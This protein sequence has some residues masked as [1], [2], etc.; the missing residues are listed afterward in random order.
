MT[1]QTYWKNKY[2]MHE[3]SNAEIFMLT[4]IIQKPLYTIEKFIEIEARTLYRSINPS[5]YWKQQ[6]N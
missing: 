1:I 5:Q 6:K 3:W 4:N 2:K